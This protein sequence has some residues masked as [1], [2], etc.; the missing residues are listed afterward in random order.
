MLKKNQ[1]PILAIFILSVLT[2]ASGFVSHSYAQDKPLELTLNLVF[3]STHP[4]WEGRMK[5]WVESIEKASDNKIRIVPHFACVLAPFQEAYDAAATGLADISEAFIPM[6]VGRFNISTVTE[7]TP[8]DKITN[9]PST[10]FWELYEAF[11]EMQKEFSDV[12]VLS[13]KTFTAY[14]LMT[15]KPVNTLEDLKGLKIA[16]DSPWAV[17]RLNMLGATGVAMPFSEIFM[18]LQKGVVDGV[19]SPESAAVGR[20]FFDHVKFVTDVNL[21]GYYPL[22]VAMNLSTWNKLPIDIQKKIE[23]VCGAE[24]SNFFDSRGIGSEESARQKSISEFGVK[25]IQLKPEEMAKWAT[26]DKAVQKE[27]IQSMESKGLPGEKIM[28]ALAELIKNSD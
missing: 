12:K 10:V 2:F 16:S 5:T 17:K 19:T 28:V 15:K 13:L 4:R 7:V 20:R 8:I 14:R 1:R 22:I 24:A 21:A 26:I 18:A 9:K 25:Y 27:W 3:P 11:P 23:M 6:S